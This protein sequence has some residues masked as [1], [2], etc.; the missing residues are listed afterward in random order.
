[1]RQQPDPRQ[2]YAL[3]QRHCT[4]LLVGQLLGARQACRACGAQRGRR[5]HG[6][7][8][9]AYPRPL[10]GQPHRSESVPR[11]RRQH[12]H[13]YGT[14]H[15]WQHHMGTQDEELA[16]VCR[17]RHSRRFRL[18]VCLLPQHLGTHGQ[19]RGR[20]PLGHQ[21]PWQILHDVQRQPHRRRV[22]QLSARCGPGRGAYGIQQRQQ[23]S[24]SGG[25]LQP[26]SPRG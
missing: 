3:R 17:R 13:V 6:P 26:D 7:L 24:P 14:L 5:P 16:R 1:M 20:G 23:I 11:R 19:C 25:A 15:R 4:C 22:G 18:P 12:V 10:D 8:R 21:I 9:R 2:R